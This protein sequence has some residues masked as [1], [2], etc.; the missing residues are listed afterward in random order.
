MSK[1]KEKTITTTQVRIL[2]EEREVGADTLLDLNGPNIYDF[3]VRCSPV[4]T[5]PVWAWICLYFH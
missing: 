3:V 1:F 2:I 4:F 5:K